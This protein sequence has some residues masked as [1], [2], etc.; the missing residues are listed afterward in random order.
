MTHE[1]N[2]NW[3]S[4]VV[5]VEPPTLGMPPLKSNCSRYQ[6]KSLTKF[7]KIYPQ[8]R[9]DL[10]CAKLIKMPFRMWTQVGPRNYAIPTGTGTFE[11][12]W[13]QDCPHATKR[14]YQWPWHR[15][16]PTC[17]RS[18]LRAVKCHVKFSQWKIHPP[19]NACSHQNYLTSCFHWTIKTAKLQQGWKKTVSTS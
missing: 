11:G 3:I 7:H 16:F 13:R 1:T 14:R 10:F 19:N 8:L 6:G 15:D 5:S 4:A 9:E 18:V 12:R 17:C 2:I